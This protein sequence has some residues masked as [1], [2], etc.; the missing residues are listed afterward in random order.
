MGAAGAPGIAVDSD[1]AHDGV[2]NDGE[3]PGGQRLGQQQIGGAGEAAGGA[4]LPGG[5]DVQALRRR[6]K[7]LD[8]QAVARVVF[9]KDAVGKL[10]EPF[11]APGDAEHR[12]D[13]VVV[14]S[15]IF[16]FDRPVVA[17]AVVVFGFEFVIAQPVR[18]PRPEQRFAA[19]HPHAHPVIG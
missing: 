10:L 19:D 14:G 4:A 2:G 8:A 11:F 12:L 5:R 6:D 17:E 13:A 18:H 16:V 9:E 3:L 1:L 7:A 15:E